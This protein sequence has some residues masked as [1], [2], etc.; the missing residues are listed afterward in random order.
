[1]LFR[2]SHWP[3]SVFL[4]VDLLA[5][6]PCHHNF[7]PATDVAALNVFSISSDISALDVQGGISIASNTFFPMIWLYVHRLLCWWQITGIA[8]PLT[9]EILPRYLLALHIE[10]RRRQLVQCASGFTMASPQPGNLGGDDTSY[11]LLLHHP[12]GD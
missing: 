1:M 10:P 12:S 7:V 5:G 6:N 11:W 4:V 2:Y 8:W 9:V 3:D